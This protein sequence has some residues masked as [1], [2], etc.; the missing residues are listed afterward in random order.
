[1]HEAALLVSSVNMYTEM[2]NNKNASPVELIAP[3]LNDSGVMNLTQCNEYRGEIWYNKEAMQKVILI[4]TLTY[5]LT[6]DSKENIAD[7]FA[8]TLLEKEINSG[9]KLRL[10]LSTKEDE[11]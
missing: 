6:R 11:N 5:A 8:S 2:D 1:M 9:Y 3:L 10:L 4:S 7:G